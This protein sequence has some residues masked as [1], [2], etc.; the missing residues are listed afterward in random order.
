MVSGKIDTQQYREYWNQIQNEIEYEL[1]GIALASD[2]TLRNRNIFVVG[3]K[4]N[5]TYLSLMLQPGKLILIEIV[6]DG[7]GMLLHF[8]SVDNRLMNFLKE[9]SISLFSTK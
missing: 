6:E 5:K 3:K 7:P 4:D 9:N 2:D 1:T 8:K